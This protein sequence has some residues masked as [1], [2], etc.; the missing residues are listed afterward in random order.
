MPV[1]DYEPY[2]NWLMAPLGKGAHDL[3]EGCPE[4]PGPSAW[5]PDR[6]LTYAYLV[7]AIYGLAN[8]VGAVPAITSG[9]RCGPCNARR[10]GAPRS[11]HL[12]GTSGGANFGAVDIQ[13]RPGVLAGAGVLE[14]LSEVPEFLRHY[15]GLPHSQWGVIA[16]RG[17]RRLH[18][19]LRERDYV[20]DQR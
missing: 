13:W 14:N 17:D 6:A 3:V 16:Y 7:L 5:P 9:F 4:C 12:A 15:T 10:G 19:D 18:I 1:F 8:V 2:F 20:E 11:R